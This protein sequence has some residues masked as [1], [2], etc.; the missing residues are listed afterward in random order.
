MNNS[1]VGQPTSL[2]VWAT[3]ASA[4]SGEL[5][6]WPLHLVMAAGQNS[7]LVLIWV[8]LWMVTITLI[9]PSPT[10]LD[11][12]WSTV[13]AWLQGVACVV[14]IAM[15][16]IMLVELSGM[17]QTFYYF[18]TPRWAL[19]FPI[20]VIAGWGARGISAT[21]WRTISLWIPVLLSITFLILMISLTNVHFGQIL[22]PNHVIILSNQL[23]GIF[24]VAYLGLPIGVT[25][26]SLHPILAKPAPK[27]HR[28]WAAIAPWMVLS[29]LYVVTM[30]SIGDQALTRLS[31]PVVF[32]LD[33][34]TLD[35][36]FFLSRI[37]LLVV[38][39]W[40]VGVALGIMVHIRLLVIFSNTA[41][42]R[43]SHYL[44]LSIGILWMIETF[45]LKS[46]DS[47]A[48]LL[49]HMFDP[50]SSVYLLGEM[51]FLLTWQLFRK[52]RNNFSK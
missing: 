6:V 27:P 23:Q 49:T 5:F 11:G 45:I 3:T 17:L 15:D 51:G 1:Q 50:V 13:H 31:W 46:P 14:L 29:A 28:I 25:I 24:V 32:T 2:L 34:V 36:S 30:G 20:I 44:P 37:G 42:P 39:G 47:A 19:I 7:V 10:K 16:G 41:A 52:H 22:L 35:S 26:R 38:F 4:L 12:T 43:I 8:V 18:N 33:H 40:T 48:Y 21:L 9:S